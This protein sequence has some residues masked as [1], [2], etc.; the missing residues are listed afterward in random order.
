MKKILAFLLAIIMILSVFAACGK[1]EKEPASTET[2]D[3]TEPENTERVFESKAV[4][5]LVVTA[6]AFL[7]RKAYIQY[8]DQSCVAKL[9][10]LT[11][12]RRAE[13]AKNSPETATSQYNVYS[14]CTEFVYD[15]YYYALG[16]DIVTWTTKLLQNYTNRHAFSYYITGEE[17]EEQ[18]AQVFEDFKAAMKPGDILCCRHVGDT[19]GNTLLYVGD[20]KIIYSARAEAGKSPNYNYNT[21]TESFEPRGTVSTKDVDKLAQSSDDSYFWAEGW[22][23]ISRP[24]I[25]Y[26]D[27]EPT[28]EALNRIN[29]LQ[30]IVVEKLSSV[31]AANT[32][33]PGDE[34]TFTFQ[35]KNTNDTD[36]T[37]E[38]IDNI[39]QGM[40]YVSGAD[41]VDGATLKWNASIPASKTTKISYV[42][43]INDDVA[44]GTFIESDSTVGGVSANSRPL[45]I[46]KRLTADQRT[47]LAAAMDGTKKSDVYGIDLAEQIYAAAGITIELDSADD[48]IDGLYKFYNNTTS[49]Y[50]LDTSSKY[51]NMVAPSMYG[52]YQVVNTPSMWNKLRTKGPQI[53]QLMV[54]DIVIMTEKGKTNVY[55]VY[56]INRLFNL[57][58]GKTEVMN[59]QDSKNAVFATLGNDKFAVI[60]P[61]MTIQ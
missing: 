13:R 6:E 53:N 43:K 55:M 16:I 40:T 59:L 18:K 22:W 11:S 23:G 10:N 31:P 61:A 34:V 29:N 35:I 33:M 9:N 47:A 30:G 36:T 1:D 26:P 42:L 52:G 50:E 51:L 57:N 48:I 58:Q 45:F 7:G 14:N 32:A 38:I 56:D 44:E 24:L 39:P 60:R 54:G 41:T 28:E 46:G 19:G 25:E 2:P 21:N 37:L 17:T 49:H 3:N 20:G 15:V 12:I 27:A 4:E 8:D 5:A